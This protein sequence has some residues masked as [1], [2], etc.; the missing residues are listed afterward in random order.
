MPQSRIY[1]VTQTREVEVNANDPVSASRIAEMAFAGIDKAYTSR[2]VEDQIGKW[3]YA[4]DVP[5]A[6]EINV[7]EKTYT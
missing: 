2:G 4:K 7:K 1:T 6:I 5:L 3:G